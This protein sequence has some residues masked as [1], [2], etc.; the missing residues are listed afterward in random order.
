MLA[1]A[2]LL[3][4]LTPVVR[5]LANF[6]PMPGHGE[7]LFRDWLE[8]HRET[9]FR[10]T[11]AHSSG[12]DVRREL[13]ETAVAIQ[14]LRGGPEFMAWLFGAALQAAAERA[15]QG[16]LAEADLTGLPPELRTMLRLSSR[17][18]FRREEA[19]ALL[20]QRMSYV[21]GRLLQSR[22]KG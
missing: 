5:R 8:A 7:P 17:Q 16:G 20:A 19:V 14:R 12:A 22:L 10:W 4:G 1:T 13:A 3:D 6:R 2:Q 15:G 18:A 21:R 9:L 11:M